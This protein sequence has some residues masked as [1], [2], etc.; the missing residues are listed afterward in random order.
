MTLT[1]TE[2][3]E[4]DAVPREELAA[5]QYE[6]TIGELDVSDDLSECAYT[7]ADG[8]AWL[9]N[10]LVNFEI[11]D[12]YEQADV[13]VRYFVRDK[14]YVTFKGKAVTVNPMGG[15]TRVEAATG[16][17]E[18]ERVPVG[19]G[20]DYDDPTADD[21]DINNERPDNV[22][23]IA[24]SMLP[25]ANIDLA[26]LSDPPIARRAV[27]GNSI[28]WYEYVEAAFATVEEAAQ[29]RVVDDS[30]NVM[31]YMPVR[32]P[33]T[34]VSSL[35][36]IQSGSSDEYPDTDEISDETSS[37]SDEGERY[38]R[39]VVRDSNGRRVGFARVD[40]GNRKVHSRSTLLVELPEGAEDSGQQLAHDTA[41]F[42]GVNARAISAELLYPP[43]MLQ[44]GMNVSATARTW[45]PD[46][47][48]EREFQFQAD[49]ITVDVKG[50]KGTL[51]G[52]GRLISSTITPL[53]L[54]LPTLN[55]AVRS[56][57]GTDPDGTPYINVDLPWAYDDGSAVV[58]D[59]EIAA[60][61]G[62]LVQDLGNNE[63]SISRA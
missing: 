53:A 36:H 38:A 61:Y 35:W 4:L 34:D 44:R 32:P 27:E 22:L 11:D 43:F 56:L 28:K 25:Y 13:V 31:R 46:I 62:I 29:V 23:F 30:L 47:Q 41:I 60:R 19:E 12:S 5:A 3:A 59:T 42:L 10:A 1:R 37:G 17:Y 55:A 9:L 2:L 8:R 48:Y 7:G 18:A 40:N 21:W 63:I 51:G 33:R 26:P 6:V 39:V 24:G 57:W 45:A 52:A 50:R 58:L 15:M 49:A 20:D 14:T 54:T 16:S